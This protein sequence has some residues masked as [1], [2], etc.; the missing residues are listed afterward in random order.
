MTM[1]PKMKGLFLSVAEM[2][3]APT[4]NGERARMRPKPGTFN[5]LLGE[6]Q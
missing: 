2:E 1:D 6:R 4:A 5:V 3:S